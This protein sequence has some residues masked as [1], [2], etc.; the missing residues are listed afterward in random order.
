MIRITHRATLL[1]TDIRIC[2]LQHS[3][4]V[5]IVGIIWTYKMVVCES[6]WKERERACKASVG[7]SAGGVNGADGIGDNLTVNTER[8]LP[9]KFRNDRDSE[10]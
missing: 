1:A 9:V 5:V 3:L 4:L 8:R 6:S 7:G 10:E 2:T